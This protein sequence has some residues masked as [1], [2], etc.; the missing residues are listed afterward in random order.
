MSVPV[1][2]SHVYVTNFYSGQVAKLDLESGKVL[3][4]VETGIRKSLS[5]A[6]E[7]PG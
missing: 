7:F 3:A 5:G 1:A 6:A 4:R 2:G